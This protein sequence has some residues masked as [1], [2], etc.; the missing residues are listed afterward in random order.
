MSAPGKFLWDQNQLILE[1]GNPMTGA[2]FPKWIE[3]GLPLM[4]YQIEF[5]AQ[6]IEG[7]DFFATLTFPIGK[8]DDAVSL[9]L[10]GWGGN[11]IGISCI[12]GYDASENSTT[13]YLDFKNG[14]WYHLR[15]EVHDDWLRVWLNE[16][17]I[18]QTNLKGRQ[19][20]LRGGDII[21]CLPFGFASYLSKGA[22]RNLKIR[23]ISL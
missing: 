5:E 10:G 9:V 7:N 18:V 12:D 22:I 6:R 19:L 3:E 8:I 20:S 11:L 2:F 16:R 23:Q 14:T 13:S 21:H 15:I 4:N 1:L 17:P